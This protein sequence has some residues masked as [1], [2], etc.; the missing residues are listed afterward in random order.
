MDMCVPLARHL[1]RTYG[2]DVEAA[3]QTRV[4]QRLIAAFAIRVHQNWRVS[5]GRHLKRHRNDGKPLHPPSHVVLH[6]RLPDRPGALGAVA[7]RIG[8]VGAD[9]T[10]VI[11]ARHGDGSAVDAF[12]LTL[13]ATNVDVLALLVQEL[14]EVDGASVESCK[15][16]TCCGAAAD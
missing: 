6:V 13:P 7:S 14:R 9:I 12:H 2:I 5:D 15:P 11:V 10:D 3:R 16:A 1:V 8:A 4:S